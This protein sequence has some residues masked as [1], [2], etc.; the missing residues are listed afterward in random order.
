MGLAWAFC[1]TEGGAGLAVKDKGLYL[2][3]VGVLFD[4]RGNGVGGVRKG[5]CG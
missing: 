2:R 1:F 5:L 3:C 4:E